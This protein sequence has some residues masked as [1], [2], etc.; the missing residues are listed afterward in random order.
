MMG[1]ARRGAVMADVLAAVDVLTLVAYA[2]AVPIC[3]LKGKYAIG[4]FGVVMFASGAVLSFPL[5]Q[6]YRDGHVAGWYWLLWSL[7]GVAIA[8]LMVAMSRRPAR[9]GS[10]SPGC[11]RRG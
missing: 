9:P 2:A 7:Q 10:R 11:S 5:Y 3:F 4:W 8:L 1:V 6:L